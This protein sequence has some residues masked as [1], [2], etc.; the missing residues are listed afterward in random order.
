MKYTPEAIQEC[1]YDAAVRQL[2]A[3]NKS[4]KKISKSLSILSLIG[5]GVVVYKEFKYVKGE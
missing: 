2:H 4:L 3:I 1:Q 5:I